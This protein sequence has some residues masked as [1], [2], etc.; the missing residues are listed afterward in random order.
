MTG[1][2]TFPLYA[3]SSSCDSETQPWLR[4]ICEVSFKLLDPESTNDIKTSKLNQ[5]ILCFHFRKY[6]TWQEKKNLI[7]CTS[8]AKGAQSFPICLLDVVL[9]RGQN[10]CLILVCAFDT[11]SWQGFLGVGQSDEL[12]LH[13][14]GE[15]LSTPESRVWLV[16][17]QNKIFTD[18]TDFCQFSFGKENPPTPQLTHKMLS[19]NCV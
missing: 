3:L 10:L 16:L 17:G 5:P 12:F 7:I 1:K 13:R 15:S 14:C 18:F 6:K 4:L 11:Q 8:I 9:M 2:S 19:D